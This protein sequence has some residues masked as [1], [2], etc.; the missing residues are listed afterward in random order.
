[1]WNFLFSVQIASSLSTE[2]WI[3]DSLG[4]IGNLTLKNLTLPGTHD[5]GAYYLT[6]VPMPG[7]QASIV[8]ALSQLAQI[9]NESYAEVA[10]KWAQSQDKTFYQQMQGGIRYFDLRSGWNQTTQQWLAF[11]FLQGTL[12]SYLLQNIP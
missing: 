9:L 12:V 11:H 8:Q 4:V 5:S 7:A 2:T 10:K 3:G 6:D 1:M